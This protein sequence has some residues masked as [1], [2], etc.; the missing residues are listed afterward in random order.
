MTKATDPIGVLL[1]AYGGP[2]SLDDIEPY[3]L[4]IRGGRPTS[5]ELVA[6]IQ[7][8]Y[9]QIGGKSPLLEVTRRQ[10]AALEAA[11]GEGFKVYVGMRHWTPRIAETVARMETDGIQRAVALVAA[12]HYSAM[13]VGAYFRRL[14]EAESTIEFAR[15]EDW[16]D[17]PGLVEALAARAREALARF[18]GSERVKVMFTAHS[19]P[20]RALEGGDP[21]DEQL[22]RTAQLVA[23]KLSLTDWDFCYQSAG[24]SPEPWLGPEIE[25]VI[26]QEAEGGTT[27]LLVVPVGFVSDH[28]EVL[29]DIDIEAKGIAE[30]AGLRL[31]RPDSLNDD[32]TFV[33]AMA[34]VVRRACARWED[35]AA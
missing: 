2:D 3:L 30:Q 13:S 12:P 11:L 26:P 16:H 5:P 9:A 4:D 32:P 18:P 33:G 15:V 14:D 34:A 8:R 1:M 6:E 29:Y 10:A 27:N 35:V 7:Q 31:E 23:D 20:V 24:R 17:E 19:L 21:Y 28:V 25:E 22:R